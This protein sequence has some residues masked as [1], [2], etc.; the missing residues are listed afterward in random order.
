M[1]V[2]KERE[3][4]FQ[5]IRPF[6]LISLRTGQ[7]IRPFGTGTRHSCMCDRQAGWLVG[8]SYVPLAVGFS[9]FRRQLSPCSVCLCEMCLQSRGQSRLLLILKLSRQAGRSAGWSSPAWAS[10]SCVR[11]SVRLWCD[12]LTWRWKKFKEKGQKK[13][14]GRQG[15]F[16]LVDLEKRTGQ[17]KQSWRKENLIPAVSQSAPFFLSFVLR[18][19]NSDR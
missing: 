13:K 14:T 4:V 10:Q 1:I 6:R 3:K 11:P 9:S 7:S 19:Y 16:A 15:K 17:E 18:I 12:Q 5:V 8:M 2:K